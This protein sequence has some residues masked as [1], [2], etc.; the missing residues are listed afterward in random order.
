[1]PRAQRTPRYA[2]IEDNQ[3]ARRDSFAQSVEDGLG[4]PP[5]SLPCRVF[6][7]AEGSRLFEAICGL[8][9]Y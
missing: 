2:W 6:Y 5:Y 4:A 8:P 9:E 7:D 3:I 1:M